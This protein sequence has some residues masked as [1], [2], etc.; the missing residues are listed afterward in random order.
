MVIEARHFGYYFPQLSQASVSTEG[1]ILK[2]S[3][4]TSPGASRN[5]EYRKLELRPERTSGTRVILS[6]FS[7]LYFQ[8]HTRA[9]E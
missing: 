7:V 8:V 2:G 3:E 9:C 4:E 5:K 1:E 6:V